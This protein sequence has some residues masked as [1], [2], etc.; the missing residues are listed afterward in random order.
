M[1]VAEEVAHEAESAVE[2]GAEAVKDV[3]RKKAAGQVVQNG[4]NPLLLF[5]FQHSLL[6]NKVELFS[7]C[8]VC[9][10]YSFSEYTFFYKNTRLKFGQNVRT[11]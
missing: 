2:E 11:N 10:R 8:L 4:I 7:R 6:L 3:T 5:I 1:T 9:C